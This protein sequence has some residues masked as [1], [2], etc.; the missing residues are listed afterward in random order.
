VAVSTVASLHELASDLQTACETVLA[1]TVGGPPA[2]AS[3]SPGL[4]ALDRQC[5]QLWV[6]ATSPTVI[7]SGPV[8]PGASMRYAVLTRVGL[9]ATIARCV[10]VAAEVNGSYR[11][12]SAAQLTAAAR[13]V[14]EDAWGLWNGVVTR[15]FAGELFEGHPCQGV[16]FDSLT[17]LDP[18]GGFGGWTLALSIELDGYEVL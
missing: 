13:K 17:P 1:T 11:V 2:I 16:S 7:G 12:P 5:D 10:P 14:M 9:A 6:Y 18:Q 4:P 8:T 3:F 15:I